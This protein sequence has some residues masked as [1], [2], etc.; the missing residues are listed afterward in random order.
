[1]LK[2][3]VPVV[4]RASPDGA[5]IAFNTAGVM[6][7]DV[8]LALLSTAS[9]NSKNV[10]TGLRINIV[11][12]WSSD[13]KH[14]LILGASGGAGMARNT[15]LYAVPFE[16][17]AAIPLQFEE[18]KSPQR[19]YQW[20]DDRLLTSPRGTAGAIDEF[21][22]DRSSWKAEGPLRRLVNFPGGSVGSASAAGAVLV[23][24]RSNFI[25]DIWSIPIDAVRGVV[26]GSARKLT[27]DEASEAN[28][29]ISADGS[30]M[31]YCSDRS[32]Q[33]DIWLRDMATGKETQVT[34]NPEAET[35]ARISPDGSKILYEV[36]KGERYSLHVR[37]VA[38][39]D[40][41]Q[42]CEDCRRP[43]WAPDSDLV[44]YFS[45][46]PIRFHS[47]RL[48][49]GVRTQVVAH[50]TRSVQ[51]LE[52]SPDGKWV[53]FHLPIG[54]GATASLHRTGARW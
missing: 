38:G 4:M 41:R 5:W 51:S 15:R 50:P 28:P 31:V 44:T 32:G 18:G 9:G 54:G 8:R 47:L 42:V 45:G 52:F 11:Q 34:A 24:E 53:S 39:G 27:N 21:R 29:T 22:L 35:R 33:F 20:L 49:S 30:R 3:I 23:F 19:V 6:G 1:M 25:S 12:G 43:A 7:E 48:S 13:S 2:Q 14:V 36:V 10:Q 37:D 17:G 16:G 26:T 40:A 46:D